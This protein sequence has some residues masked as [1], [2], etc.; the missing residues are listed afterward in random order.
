MP[1]RSHSH[2][3]LFGRHLR[4]LRRRRRLS[5]RELAK[6]AGLDATGISRL[7]RGASTAPAPRTLACLAR[8][9]DVDVADLYALAGYE[10]A[11]DLPTFTPYLRARYDLPQEA[12]EQLAAHFELVN[13]RYGRR[14]DAA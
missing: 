10:V 5:L 14:G 12:I 9:L 8:A 1:T 11:R 13:T 3:S 6:R 4:D 7:E 2:H